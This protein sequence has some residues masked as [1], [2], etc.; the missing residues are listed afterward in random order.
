MALGNK[1]SLTAHELLIKHP[2]TCDH[3]DKLEHTKSPMILYINLLHSNKILCSLLC[4]KINLSHIY[5]FTRERPPVMSCYDV[6]IKLG[7]I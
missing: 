4:P 6:L 2:Q 3:L 1:K 5:C 7:V